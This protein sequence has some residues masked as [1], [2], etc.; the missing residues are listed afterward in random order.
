[1]ELRAGGSCPGAHRATLVGATPF[2]CVSVGVILC[3]SHVHLAM[4]AHVKVHEV[5]PRLHNMLTFT[6]CLGCRQME[7]V[8]EGS[9]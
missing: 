1:V 9:G 3:P 8:I 5:F 4:V 6:F 2:T 7:F